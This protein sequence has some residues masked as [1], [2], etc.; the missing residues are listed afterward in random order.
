MRIWLLLR[1][2][3]SCVLVYWF[4]VFTVV[5]VGWLLLW[6]FSVVV[7]GLHACI[8]LLAYIGLLSIWVFCGVKLFTLIAVDCYLARV[9]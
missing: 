3:F 6:L 8:W 7:W 4:V 2:S 1:S 9:L 5:L